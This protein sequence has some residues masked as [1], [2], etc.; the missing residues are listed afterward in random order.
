MVIFFIGTGGWAYLEYRSNDKLKRYSREFD[1][2]EVNS[3]FYTY[4]N[5]STVKSWR[6]RVPDNFVF[7]VKCNRDLTHRYLL[8]PNEESY[9]IF[10]RM[11][12]ICYEL[13][14]N[15]L[16]LQTPHYLELNSQKLNEIE[17]LLNSIDRGGI[18]IV[19]DIRSRMEKESWAKLGKIMREY[20][21]IDASDLTI[22]LP[23]NYDKMIY[24]RIVGKDLSA[25][26]RITKTE[27]EFVRDKIYDLD[28][29]EAYLAFHPRKMYED[30]RRF[31]RL[32]DSKS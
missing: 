17:I 13:K 28:P 29:K 19:W 16:I 11:K 32:I 3:T 18:T 2:V 9:K 27:M 21:I 30:A 4:P 6:R 26:G 23:K 22:T 20:N 12:N 25:T 24:S 7:S 31:K 14:S 8:K 10:D 5:L 15:I 1:F